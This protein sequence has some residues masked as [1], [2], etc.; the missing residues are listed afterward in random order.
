METSSSSPTEEIEQE[1]IETESIPSITHVNIR[2]SIALAV[3]AGP[4]LTFNEST[5]PKNIPLKNKRTPET[6][7]IQGYYRI[8]YSLI[9]GAPNVA[10]DI[11]VFR[12]AAKIYPDG[13]KAYVI[14]TWEDEN[15]NVW[16]I[17]SHIHK[18]E[19]NRE[20]LLALLSQNILVKI[21]DGRDFCTVRTKL[22]KP[23]IGRLPANSMNDDDNE[24]SPKNIVQ[25]MAQNYADKWVAK[26]LLYKLQ[27]KLPIR[28][29]S[30]TPF[31][32]KKIDDMEDVRPSTPVSP[33]VFLETSMES[34]SGENK[35]TLD[36]TM[37]QSSQSPHHGI[38][39]KSP[40]K[41]ETKPVE[42]VVHKKGSRTN[43]QNDEKKLNG[44]A[45][46]VI[47]SNLIFAGY[48]TITY[49]L[50]DDPLLP[51]A[52]QDCFVSINIEDPELMH[53][54]LAKE[55]NPLTI[56]ICHAENMPSTPIS[57]TELKQR[58]EP[59][60]C[61]YQLFS[62]P[63]HQTPKKSQAR[64][65][66]WHDTHIY[67]TN[68]IDENVLSHF[69]NSPFVNIEL[70]DRDE[71]EHARRRI[72]SVF[73]TESTD[74]DIGRVSGKLKYHK[75]KDEL[76]W[77]PYGCVKL[78]LTELWLGQTS[79]EFYIPVVPCHAPGNHS[80]RTSGANHSLFN[81][82]LSMQQGDFLS[83]GTQMKILVKLAKPL[84]PQIEHRLLDDRQLPTT[85]IA[86]FSRIAFVFPYNNTTFL[87]ALQTCIRILNAKALN[88]DNQ[89]V[90]A[91]VTTLS[92][93]KL[94]DVQQ[95][96]TNLNILTGFHLFDDEQHI[97]VL[98]GRKE[99]AIDLLYEAIP[100]P[101]GQ[102]IEILYD[103]SVHFNERLYVKF[104]IDIIHI[105]LSRTL[106][107]I[108]SH[109]LIF[110]RNSLTKETFE[111]LE[112]LHQLVLVHRLNSS[113]RYQLFPTMKMI[114]SLNKDF[115]VPLSENEIK[116]FSTDDRLPSTTPPPQPSVEEEHP[117][118]E[119]NYSTHGESIE[120]QTFPSFNDTQPPEIDFVARNMERVR[121]TSLKENRPIDDTLFFTTTG[122]VYPYSTQKLNSIENAREQMR[123]YLQQNHHSV[124]F[125]FNPDYPS[126]TY[127]PYSNE[128]T[129]MDFHRNLRTPFDFDLIKSKEKSLSN[130]ID[131][132][133][134]RS[135]Q[136][137]NVHPKLPDSARLDELS[138][139]PH[140]WYQQSIR[141]SQ[142]PIIIREPC[143][144]NHR[145][146]DFD[147]WTRA[148]PLTRS[149]SAHW[150][151]EQELSRTKSLPSTPAMIVANQRMQFV[152]RSAHTEM[153]NE[154]RLSATQL[155]RLTG[156]LKDKP[157][158]KGLLLP[159]S[160][161]RYLK[162]YAEKS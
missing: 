28:I 101:K 127:S 93:Y 133:G 113:A 40:E 73:G 49:R 157:I 79:L 13:Q 3:P 22:D 66:Y 121:L 76:N 75:S 108:V 59:V 125:S 47:P 33:D 158:K 151:S 81:E 123:T 14:P 100:K 124:S 17:W 87:T 7:K 57:Y 9:P 122:P 46:I 102:N 42:N 162:A 89:P 56:T 43:K 161:S 41:I 116:L 103:S 2:I 154:G 1:V 142:S 5:I 114:T 86:P 105:R 140:E 18:L 141:D 144:W 37:I 36:G 139:P 95:E 71:C 44:I 74:E 60:Y 21:W 90:H 83:S 26:P 12:T 31:L 78:D 24:N 111:A 62:Q 80:G 160:Y 61:S 92:T 35:M 10:Y 136:R 11:V 143:K 84:V 32:Q 97:F 149:V 118:I 91:Q 68:L 138:K 117:I 147:R 98:E 6:T 48:K 29:P 8:E 64:H 104:G 88:F 99:E 129:V 15:E 20:H 135:S 106:N 126:L 109:P 134:Y 67:L 131:T 112:K 72:G 30:P 23:R 45:Q 153:I 77:H 96:N 34:L 39:K 107:N 19:L 16:I 128:E 52:I 148:P 65:I 155:D 51:R 137:C 152:R 110:I 25:S 54:T 159:K 85:I 70:H 119:H 156:I 132:P 55:F 50:G 53:G 146:E 115:G 130:W 69:R 120:G 145:N 94:T 27:R 63:I 4:P 150:Q 38:L 58:C 82:N